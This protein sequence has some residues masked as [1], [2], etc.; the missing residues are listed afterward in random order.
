MQVLLVAN[1]FR[2]LS[3]ELILAQN[4]GGAQTFPGPPL[5]FSCPLVNYY[6]IVFTDD[7]MTVL[8][9]VVQHASRLQA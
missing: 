2:R 5:P 7:T 3:R 1:D 9:I 4:F 6:H 8:G